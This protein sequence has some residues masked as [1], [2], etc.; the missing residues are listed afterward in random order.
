MGRML[1]GLVLGLTGLGF[2]RQSPPPEGTPPTVAQEQTV[3]RQTA[4]E[5]AEQSSEALTTPEVQQLIRDGL[6]SEP[7]LAD[8]SVRVRTDDRAIVLMGSVGSDKQHEL[9]LRI[10]QSF[11]GSRQIVDKITIMKNASR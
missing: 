7:A 2:A 4:P 1:F 8:T 3:E 10:A 11:T 5:R 6:S 9:A